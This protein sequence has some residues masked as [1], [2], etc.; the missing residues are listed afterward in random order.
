MQIKI[1]KN[2]L[3][4]PGQC[5]SESYGSLSIP[6]IKDTTNF[7]IV[8]TKQNGLPDQQK[9]RAFL[10]K[11]VNVPFILLVSNT[12]ASISLLLS[13]AELNCAVVI[14]PKSRESLI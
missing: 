9:Y 14:L 3:A 8:L 5:V 1:I 6:I 4:Q 2:L 11:Y 10:Q 7:P 12:I 13:C